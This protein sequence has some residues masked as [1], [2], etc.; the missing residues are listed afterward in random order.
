MSSNPTVLTPAG[1]TTIP[2]YKDMVNDLPPM[3]Q[4]RLEDVINQYRR[5]E[6]GDTEF[7]AKV[8]ATFTHLPDIP[9]NQRLDPRLLDRAGLTVEQVK[10]LVAAGAVILPM[11]APDSEGDSGNA[12][13]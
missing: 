13:N 4:L 5:G 10:S 3:W 12:S 2:V 7:T 11:L 9:G 8:A 1:E 6:V